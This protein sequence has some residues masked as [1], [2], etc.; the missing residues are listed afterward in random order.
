MKIKILLITLFIQTLC[1]AQFYYHV[2]DVSSNKLIYSEKDDKIYASIPSSNGDNGNSIGI[3]NPNT[4][5][6]EETFYIGS[7]PTE[8][9][10]SK[11]ENYIYVGFDGAS[12]IRRFNTETKIAEKPFTLGTDSSSG[13]FYAE[14]IEVLPNNPNAIA[15]SRKN[16]GISPRHEG[17]AIY[18]NGVARK[19]TTQDHTGSNSITFVNNRTLYGY[20]NESTEYGLRDLSI[21]ENGITEGTVSEMILQGSDVDIISNESTI[22]Y[23]TNGSAIDVSNTPFKTGQFQEANGPVVYDTANNLVCFGTSTIF[24]D[25][26]TF[27]RFNA[28]NY[29]LTDTLTFD[30][31]DNINGKVLSITT[32]G[33]NRYAINTKNKIIIIDENNLETKNFALNTK[34]KL[35]YY[36]NPVENHFTLT[37]SN[38]NSIISIKVTDLNGRVIKNFSNVTNQHQYDISDLSSGIYILF[39]QT[40]ATNEILRSKIIKK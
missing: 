1:N 37:A 16:K 36:P 38:S 3:I 29:L 28:S 20:N 23:A 9:A 30:P 25:E 11:D 34:N 22:L 13:A 2:L 4:Y 35:Q 15:V 5:T 24:G 26:I 32:C 14:D 12:T 39:A 17:V 19:N 40:G 27:Q 31:E 18:E 7:E 6:L 21:D 10:I 33:N 8:M